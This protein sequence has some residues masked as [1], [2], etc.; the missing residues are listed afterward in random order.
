MATEPALSNALEH[1]PSRPGVYQFLDAHGRLLY[2]GKAKNLALRVR[3]YFRQSSPSPWVTRMTQDIARVEVVEV[4]SELEARLLEN[5]LI[6]SLKPK[7]NLQL[8]DDKTF[9]FI[10]ISADNIPIF[11][12]T[13]RVKNDGARYFGPYSSANHL[14]IILNILQ[15]M[16]GIRT[17]GPR[18]YA[19]RS[20]V[21]AQIGAPP[22]GADNP[23]DYRARVDQAVSFLNSPPPS[24]EKRLRTAMT[25]A[26][27]SHNFELAAILR[28][29]LMAFRSWRQPQ[30]LFLPSGVDR[31]YIG[32]AHAGSVIAVFQ[33]FERDGSTTAPRQFIFDDPRNISVSERLGAILEF[34]YSHPAIVPAEIVVP[35]LPKSVLEI[36]RYLSHSRGKRVT[37]RV[38]LR[39][40]WRAK[41]D[42]AM[43]NARYQLRL[44]A[45]GQRRREN[46][47]T[48]LAELLGLPH[49]LH[50][51]EAFDVSN[52]GS[53]EAVG[54]SV[55]FIDGQP[56]KNEYRQ[57]IIKS[58]SGQNDFAAMRDIVFRRIQNSRRVQ[59]DLILVDGGKGQLSAAQDA[60]KLA[61]RHFPVVALAKKN[62]Q[63]YL[64]NQSRPLII[65]HDAPSLLLLTAIRD[66]VHRFGLSFHRRRRRKNFLQN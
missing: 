65:P 40:K 23:G 4:Q 21:P 50:R 62:E 60:F 16:Y 56:A 33:F 45:F 66:E 20:Q 38:P 41:A 7:Y 9:P 64:P 5:R 11:T 3:T 6:K 53:S 32:I 25:S 57:Y 29:R 24:V 27:G 43:E 15:I 28:D 17:T 37:I 49:P 44:E 61:G 35:Q 36:S 13:R 31:D 55:A 30:N 52:L 18:S 51:I 14:K 19:A 54:A 34:L 22:D 63:L 48:N 47:L 42:L 59:P 39:G 10:R 26:A 1:L 2:V 46:G 8:R 58:Q 12:I